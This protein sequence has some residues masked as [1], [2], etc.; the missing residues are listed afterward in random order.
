ME[1]IDNDGIV[2]EHDNLIP[3]ELYKNETKLTYAGNRVKK[4]LKSLRMKL[5]K[6]IKLMMY[7][8]YINFH[9]LLKKILNIRKKLLIL[10]L[11]LKM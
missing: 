11:L 2:G 10:I 8:Y 1:V 4:F 9:T 7:N 5:T 6:I 3:L